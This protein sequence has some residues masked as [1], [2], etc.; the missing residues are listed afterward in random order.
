MRPDARREMSPMWALDK[1]TRLPVAEGGFVRGAPFASPSASSIRNKSEK[2][3][4]S[5][6]QL[7]ALAIFHP[8]IG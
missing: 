4:S 5:R 3:S 1:V 7:M 2:V 8:Q 6:L